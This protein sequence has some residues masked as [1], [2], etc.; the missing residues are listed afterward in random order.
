MSLEQRAAEL[1]EARRLR[2]IKS[3]SIDVEKYLHANDVTIKVRQCR[4]FLDAI[5]NPSDTEIL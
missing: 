5:N 1:D 3:D 2:V 4:D